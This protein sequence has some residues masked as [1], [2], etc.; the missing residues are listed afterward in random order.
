VSLGRAGP[1]GPEPPE[2]VSKRLYVFVDETGNRQGDEFVVAVISAPGHAREALLG[3]MEAVERSA[4]TQGWAKWTDA[5][6]RSRDTYARAVGHLLRTGRLHPICYGVCRT[7]DDAP[8]KTAE[9]IWAAVDYMQVAP[10]VPIT[11][12]VDGLNQAQRD[13]LKRHLKPM[14][15]KQRIVVRGGRDE[16]ENNALLR[17]ADA[18]AGFIAHAR[19]RRSDTLPLWE[20]LRHGYVL[21]YRDGVAN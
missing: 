20:A 18:A 2:K 5:S 14:K 17:L 11:L 16:S 3:A 7:N 4:H 6:P 1:T 9:V 12:Q 8:R 15:G 10:D 13:T 19:Q 21:V